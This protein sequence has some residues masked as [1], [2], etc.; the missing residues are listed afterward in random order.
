MLPFSVGMS[1][2]AQAQEPVQGGAM[3]AEPGVGPYSDGHVWLGTGLATSVVSLTV[4]PNGI[5]LVLGVDGAVYQRTGDRQWLPVLGTQGI[6]LGAEGEIDEEQV[7]LDAEG[8][9]SDA[10]DLTQELEDENIENV[11]KRYPNK[12]FVDLVRSTNRLSGGNY[13]GLCW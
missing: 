12:I 13:Q 2:T 10:M 7:L 9:L 6:S 3:V 4:T 1:L 5:A 8:F 11:M